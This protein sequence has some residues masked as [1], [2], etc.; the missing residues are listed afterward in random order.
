MYIE[1]LQMV[2]WKDG[3]EQES[4]W[5]IFCL[6]NGVTNDKKIP[7]DLI[8]INCISSFTVYRKSQFLLR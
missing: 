1:M 2:E 5:C 3:E 8:A 4:L 7:K 6:S